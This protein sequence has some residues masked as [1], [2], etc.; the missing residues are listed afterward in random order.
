MQGNLSGLIGLW[1]PSEES[2]RYYAL[3]R[4]TCFFLHPFVLFPPWFLASD[5]P[6]Y[7]RM[8]LQL[9]AGHGDRRRRDRVLSRAQEAGLTFAI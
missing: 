1:S 2:G 3:A 4:R 7:A 6:L 9:P 5:W 8:E